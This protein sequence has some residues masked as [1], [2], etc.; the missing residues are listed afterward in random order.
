M[1]DRSTLRLLISV[2]LAAYGI[3]I[4]AFIPGLMVAPAAMTLLLLF[5]MQAACAFVAAY[6]VWANAS[7]AP[8]AVV[9]LAAMVAL[10]WLI[11]A[12]V[13]GIVAWLYALMAAAVAILLALLIIFAL[14]RQDPLRVA[15][16]RV[17]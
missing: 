2:A 14:T 3:Y 15:P 8:A 17:M 12:F 16:R 4:A 11:E 9:L 5:L 10:T 1:D 7:W 6:A 13:L